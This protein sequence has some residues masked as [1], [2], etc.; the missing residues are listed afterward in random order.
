M[1]LTIEEKAIV[2]RYLSDDLSFKS[3]INPYWPWLM[4]VLGL[5]LHGMFYGDVISSSL[6]NVLFVFYAYWFIS[7]GSKSGQCL[8]SAIQKYEDEVSALGE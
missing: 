5:A 3:T 7:E 1:N 4:P 6:A 8:K 2:S